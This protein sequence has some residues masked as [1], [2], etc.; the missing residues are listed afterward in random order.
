MET[1]HS[2]PPPPPPPS[3]RGEY[4]NSMISKGRKSGYNIIGM[5]GGAREQGGTRISLVPETKKRVE[6]YDATVLRLLVLIFWTR[7]LPNESAYNGDD[8]AAHESSGSR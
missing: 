1:T 8:A 3:A 4:D 5:K 6:R 7:H 2:P